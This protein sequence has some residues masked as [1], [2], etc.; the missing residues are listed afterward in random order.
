[1]T[2][3]LFLKGWILLGFTKVII[4]Q[5]YKILFKT[6]LCFYFTLVITILETFYSQFF[7][8]NLIFFFIMFDIMCG[9]YW[10]SISFFY[11]PRVEPRTKVTGFNPTQPVRKYVTKWQIFDNLRRIIY[12]VTISCIILDRYNYRLLY[13]GSKC[14]QGYF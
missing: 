2:I 3:H 13:A 11:L 12:S 6:T 9:F 5:S 10:M 1:M 4:V 8:E 14:T 7:S